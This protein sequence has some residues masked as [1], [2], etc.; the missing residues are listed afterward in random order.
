M[1]HNYLIETGSKF[2]FF[3][4]NSIMYL[5][6][7]FNFLILQFYLC[8]NGELRTPIYIKKL[9]FVKQRNYLL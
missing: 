7:E 1:L 6:L 8:T 9:S 3:Y 2:Y 5:F 4:L